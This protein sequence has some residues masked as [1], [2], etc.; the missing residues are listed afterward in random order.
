MTTTPNL[1]G[2]ATHCLDGEKLLCGRPRGGA[3]ATRITAQVN[4]KLC[5][6]KLYPR[7]RPR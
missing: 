4:C 1:P 7:K 3:L 6:A 5:L 2:I